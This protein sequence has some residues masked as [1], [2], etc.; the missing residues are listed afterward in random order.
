MISNLRIQ[1]FK[2]FDNVDLP[3]EKLTLLAGVNGAGK[4]TAVQALLLLRQAFVM[5]SLKNDKLILNGDL[6]KIGTARDALFAGSDEDNIVFGVSFTENPDSKY[7]WT[8]DY[9]RENKGRYFLSGASSNKNFPPSGLFGKRFVYLNAER[10]GPRLT[11]PMSELADEKIHVGARGEFA[12]HC[13]DKFSDMSIPNSLLALE[14][15]DGTVNRT[16]GHQAQLWM[17]H[18][19]PNVTF[20]VEAI[21][22]ADCM[23]LEVKVYDDHSG[24]LRATNMGF[25][26]SYTLPIVVAG[27]MAEP[28][29]MLIVENPEAHL[30]PA[31]QSQLALFL[32]AVAANHVQVVLETHS[33]HILNGIRI[34]VKQKTGIAHDDVRI[35]FFARENRLGTNIVQNP[36]IFEDGGIDDWPKGFFDQFEQDLE[37][38][39]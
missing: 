15:E 5:E 14:A 10:L 12:A 24:Y 3:F 2:C 13:L 8:F 34:A 30:H 1:R 7:D 17:R 35:L 19:I 26:F 25:G 16:L 33:D 20:H 28:G 6:V 38:L 11:Y 29:T 31:G 21:E 23:R 18:F 27:L 36:K 22:K 9:D 37:R 39:F 4:S 32:A